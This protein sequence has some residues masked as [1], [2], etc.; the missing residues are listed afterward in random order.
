MADSTA[1]RSYRHLHIQSAADLQ[2]V[3]SSD[4]EPSHVES[5]LY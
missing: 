4:A 3:E 1:G 5:W 2:L